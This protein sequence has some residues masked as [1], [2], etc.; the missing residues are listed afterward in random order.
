MVNGST[1]VDNDHVSPASLIAAVKGYNMRANK[2]EKNEARI[3]K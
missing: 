2:N 3:V 1:G